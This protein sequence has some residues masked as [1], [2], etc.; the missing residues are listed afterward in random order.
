MNANKQLTKALRQYKHNDNS[1]FVAGYD[2]NDV[3]E[4][5]IYLQSQIIDLK[6]CLRTCANSANGGLEQYKN[7]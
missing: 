5:V 3:N 7:D 2:I 6:A 1:G 4:L